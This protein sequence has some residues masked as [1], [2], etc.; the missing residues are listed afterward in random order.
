MDGDTET[1]DISGQSMNMYIEKNLWILG[2]HIIEEIVD[3]GQNRDT[4]IADSKEFEHFHLSPERFNHFPTETD[5]NNVYQ[6]FPPVQ[7]DK[8]KCE[9]GPNPEFGIGQNVAWSHC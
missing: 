9:G 5:C 4:Q 3:G 1:G 8:A 2:K 6:H 7:F